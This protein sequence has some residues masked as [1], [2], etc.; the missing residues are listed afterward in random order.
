MRVQILLLPIGL[1]LP[2]LAAC[3]HRDAPQAW[4][5]AALAP[6]PPGALAFC[7]A[8]GGDC[9]QIPAASAMP[10]GRTVNAPR[11]WY[12]FCQR[13]REAEGCRG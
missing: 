11:G 5:S 6:M 7:A 13:H 10:E 9:P 4:T 3:S 12:G 1:L 2:V 8:H